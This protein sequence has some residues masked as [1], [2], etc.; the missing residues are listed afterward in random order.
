MPVSGRIELRLAVISFSCYHGFAP[1]Y[2]SGE[3][4]AV[5][6][7]QGR[8]RLRSSASKLLLRPLARHPTIGGR[9]FPVAAADLWNRLPFEITNA[10][11]VNSFKSRMETYLLKRLLDS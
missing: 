6:T 10:D 2:L 4:L 3:L 11:S 7:L 9:S 1:T 5:S 8:Q